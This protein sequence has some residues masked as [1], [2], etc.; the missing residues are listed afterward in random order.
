LSRRKPKV[1]SQWKKRE[2]I[3]GDISTVVRV[4]IPATPFQNPEDPLIT[5][6]FFQ[7][8]SDLFSEQNIVKICRI[9]IFKKDNHFK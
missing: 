6:Q 4:Q 9:F 2:R 8:T 7:K 3:A 5:N 1:N